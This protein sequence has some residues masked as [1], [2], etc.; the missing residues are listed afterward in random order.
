M[1]TLTLI[2]F[3]LFTGTSGKP[4]VT[5]HNPEKAYTMRQIIQQL[6]SHL[7]QNAP[8]LYST[9]K[10]PLTNA[11]IDALEV[12]HS[13]KL[14]ADVREIYLWK[15]GQDEESY[16]S[17]YGNKTFLSLEQALEARD[18]LNEELFAKT[19]EDQ[20]KIKNWWNKDWI[21]LF[22]NGGGDYVCYDP[23][24]IFTNKP[25]QIIDY[26]HDE[27][28]RMVSAPSL[29]AHLQAVLMVFEKKYEDE[30]DSIK[31]IDKG[32]PKRFA[33]DKN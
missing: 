29:A 20:F 5:D 25:G 7:K 8:E 3:I 28:Y 14:P 9:L 11:Q 18:F 2:T 10:P 31:E 24:G 15:N 12:Q 32:Y 26:Y 21:P 16:K 27:Y 19:P 23:V 17:L 33:L 30:W 1:K 4:I 6:D 22:S 13:I